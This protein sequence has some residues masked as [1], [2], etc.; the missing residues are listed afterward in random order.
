MASFGKLVQ[1]LHLAHDQEMVRDGEDLH[2]Q[3]LVETL[4]EGMVY[5]LKGVEQ[6]MAVVSAQMEVVLGLYQCRVVL[7]L[8]CQLEERGYSEYMENKG[9]CSVK[10]EK[11]EE[12]D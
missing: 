12:A 8:A 3:E 1:G 7:T 4:E 6:Q 2:G 11:P 9:G 5:E 10:G